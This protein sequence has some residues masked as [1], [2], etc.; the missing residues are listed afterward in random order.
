MGGFSLEFDKLL[1][2]EGPDG[3]ITVETTIG[4]SDVK[5]SFPAKIDTGS[6]LCIFERSHAEQLGLRVESGIRQRVS[7][8][9]GVF[10]AFG[11]RLGLTVAGFEFD[12]LVY[13]AEDIGIRRNVLGR[14]GWLELVRIGLVDYER[15]IYLSPYL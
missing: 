10:T 7:T 4:F 1:D 2:Y 14:R 9:T 12:S 11:F 5:V 6:T 8:A 15:K 13:F 3:G